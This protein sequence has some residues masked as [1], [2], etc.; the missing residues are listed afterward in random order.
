M[1]LKNDDCWGHLK[2]GT[3]ESLARVKI[4][5]EE[6]RILWAIIN[7]TIV[8]N[9]KSDYIPESQFLEMTGISTWHQDRP[10]KGLIKKGVI[11]GKDRV[12]GLCKEFLE[13]EATPKQDEKKRATPNQEESTP[14]QDGSYTET[15][16]VIRSSQK[17]YHKKVFSKQEREK[18][19][20]EFKSGRKMMEEAI[21][22][23][24][25]EK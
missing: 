4:N 12:Y 13:F 25:R 23:A 3:S 8:F 16:V 6:S 5:G 19:L 21:N 15:G 10:I 14:N 1:R 17:S 2:R 24:L 7:K 9:K 18:K 11:F 22:K 20:K